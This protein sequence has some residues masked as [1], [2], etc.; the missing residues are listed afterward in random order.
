MNTGEYI[1]FM[2]NKENSKNCSECPENREMNSNDGELRY[3][4]GQYN[5]WVDVHCRQMERRD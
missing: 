3:P 2:F 1:N 5:C 4:C